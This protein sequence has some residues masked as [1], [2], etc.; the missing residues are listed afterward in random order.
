MTG[1]LV[2]LYISEDRG[3]S[4]RELTALRAVK[5]VGAWCFPPPPHAGHIKISRSTAIV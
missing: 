2:H 1:G 3:E 4:W 5:S